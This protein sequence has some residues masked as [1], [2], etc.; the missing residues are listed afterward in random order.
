MFTKLSVPISLLKQTRDSFNI[1]NI[2]KKRTSTNRIMT[3]KVS[4]ELLRLRS[5]A[6]LMK[7]K[8]L[9]KY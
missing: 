5:P 9:I 8:A 3:E 4:P 2:T 7:K 1:K 6:L